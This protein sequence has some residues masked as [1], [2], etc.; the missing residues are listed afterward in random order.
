MPETRVPVLPFMS[1]AAPE[2]LKDSLATAQHHPERKNLPTA[3]R[4]VV[5]AIR[6]ACADDTALGEG[7]GYRYPSNW[8]TRRMMPRLETSSRESQSIDS[9]RPPSTLGL[10]H[11][12]AAATPGR[13][14][15]FQQ[16]EGGTM[17]TLEAVQQRE[18]HPALSSG[19]RIELAREH[20]ATL[21]RSDRPRGSRQA[22]PP[23]H[24]WHRDLPAAPRSRRVRG[25]GLPTRASPQVTSSSRAR[26][27]V[28]L[29]HAVHLSRGQASTRAASAPDRANPT[30]ERNLWTNRH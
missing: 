13:R 28:R 1:R 15:G 22:S 16:R 17:T 20:H 5:P 14:L 24:R 9:H 4:R 8:S 30:M 21:G 23:K 19:E 2:N 25:G 6:H 7:A 10:E 11:V 3:K 29:L 18:A 26:S 12:K 27:R